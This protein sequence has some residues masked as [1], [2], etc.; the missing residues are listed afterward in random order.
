MVYLVYLENQ[1]QMFIK[2]LRNVNDE[3]VYLRTILD[4]R[5]GALSTYSPT[6]V[7]LFSTWIQFYFYND[8]MFTQL[9]LPQV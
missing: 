3:F 9:Y 2:V 8:N 5:D 6:P 1:G 7:L 4:L